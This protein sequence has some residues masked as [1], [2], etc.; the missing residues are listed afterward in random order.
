MGIDAVPH[1]WTKTMV[2]FW[3][4]ARRKSS[5]AQV[6]LL[7]H[8]EAWWNF[9]QKHLMGVWLAFFQPENP[10]NHLKFDADSSDSG[11]LMISASTWWYFLVI[12][13]LIRATSRVVKFDPLGW[14]QKQPQIG[15]LWLCQNS[16]WKWPFI[17]SVPIKHGGSFHSYVTVYQRV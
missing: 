5:V 9:S 2:H 13:G 16:Y 3:R 8:R 12:S 1:F 17:V 4:S 10:E 14:S 7:D 6:L 11:H 15:T